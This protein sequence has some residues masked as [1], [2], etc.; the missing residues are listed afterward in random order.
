MGYPAKTFPSTIAI[1]VVQNGH[2]RH[3]KITMFK[4]FLCG[5][6]CTVAQNQIELKY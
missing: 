1:A 5:Y 6:F 2:F 3:S 4:L